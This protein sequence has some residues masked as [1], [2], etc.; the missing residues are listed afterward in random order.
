MS[1]GPD[2]AEMHAG[3]HQRYRTIR[4][5]PFP[6]LRR[7]AARLPDLV[8]ADDHV[9]EAVVIQIEQPHAV[10]PAIGGAQRLS[11]QQVLVQSL[12]RFAEG[13]ELHFFAVLRRRVFDE[14]DDLLI[15]NP[16]VRMEDQAE[17][18]A[19]DDGGIEGRLPIAD[20]DGIVRLVPVLGHPIAGHD[21]GKLPAQSAEDI[22]VRIVLDGV[23]EGAIRRQILAKAILTVRIED[24][25]AG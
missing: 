3:M 21:A 11:T 7:P 5:D 12:L 20:G 2:D 16:A 6:R 10:V 15:A 23:D 1:V 19:F 8:V 25:F 9:H 18:A 17:H 24:Q 14:I 13:E 4:R 22:R